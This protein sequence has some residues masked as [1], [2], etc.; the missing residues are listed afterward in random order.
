MARRTRNRT[1][2]SR[3][4]RQLATKHATLII[5]CALCAGSAVALLAQTS[6]SAVELP[7]IET[8]T[9]VLEERDVEDADSEGEDTDETSMAGETRAESA[10]A[11]VRIHVDGAVASPG[12]YEVQGDDIRVMDA[13]DMAGGLTA[14]A[15]VSQV[16]LA[17]QVHDADKIH[18]PA[19]GEAPQASSSV[20]TTGSSSSGATGQDSSTLVN[21]NLASEEELCAL[22]GI[23]EA[24]AKK[25]VAERES[26]GPFASPEDLMRVSGIGEKKFASLK[27]LICV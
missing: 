25:I 1:S 3:T 7:R 14:D 16:N 11:T 8:N 9:G 23:G 4:L 21:I 18:I 26:G 17:G 22:P 12:V 2:L 19:F 10:P 24:T 20:V 13:V 15:D 6:E 27:D 5:G